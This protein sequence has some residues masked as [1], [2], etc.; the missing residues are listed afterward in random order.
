M[1]DASVQRMALVATRLLLSL[2]AEEE[3]ELA[4]FLGTTNNAAL[5]RLTEQRELVPDATVSIPEL[6]NQGRPTDQTLRSWLLQP[7]GDT[8]EFKSSA[9]TDV[10]HVVGRRPTRAPRTRDDKTA[11]VAKTACGMLNGS[12][13]YVI[14]GIVDLER[15]SLDEL[16]GAYGAVP[17]VDGRAV[18]GVNNEYPYNTG[19]EGYRRQ[20]AD[21]IDRKLSRGAAPWLRYHPVDFDGRTVCVL[22]V[23]RPPRFFFLRESKN[24][25][26]SEVFYV[27]IGAQTKPVS[28]HEMVDFMEAYPR[29]NR[30]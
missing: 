3:R 12:G 9:F 10:D 18:I 6:P 29:G 19:W 26:I 8:L 17:R 25:V 27:R 4:E 14:V 24:G 7:E 28:G 13:G 30:A 15:Y 22:E 20:L 2:S 16:N 21:A 11:E 1:P 23:G 5:P